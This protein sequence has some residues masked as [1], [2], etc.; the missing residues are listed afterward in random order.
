MYFMKIDNRAEFNSAHCIFLA[1]H[2]SID[3]DPTNSLKRC[4]ST[5]IIN[6]I[7]PPTNKAI[8]SSTTTSTTNTMNSTTSNPIITSTT[9]HVICTEINL[10]FSMRTEMHRKHQH[11][12]NSHHDLADIQLDL[13]HWLRIRGHCL[14][15]RH[16][17]HNCAKKSVPMSIAV[18]SIMNVKYI[19]PC[20]LAKA[21]KVSI[22]RHL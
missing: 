20:K 9:S 5:P 22:V 14:D 17:S 10:S 7:L 11:L 8:V 2:N 1:E 18:K 21:G 16:V 4:N 19:Q 6:H 12:T 3:F 15:L 13:A